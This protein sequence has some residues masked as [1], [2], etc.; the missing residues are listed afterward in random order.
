VPRRDGHLITAR[1]AGLPLEIAVTWL[2]WATVGIAIFATYSRFPASE[3]YNVSGTG[4]SGGLSRLFVLTNYPFGLVAIPVLAILAERLT[5]RRAHAVAVFG[6]VLAAAVFVPG[7]V[8][9]SDLDAK[10]VNAISAVGMVVALGFTLAALRQGIVRRGRGA[11]D[12]VRVAVC[13]A[14]VLVGLPWV[15]AEVG[16]YLTGV[17]GLRWLFQTGPY[18]D[19]GTYTGEDVAHGAIYTPG[20]HHGSHHGM[21]GVLLLITAALLSRVV[22]SIRRGRVRVSVG[23]YLALMAAYGIGDIANDFWT[24]QVVKRGWT[25]WG[26]PDVTRPTLTVAWAVIVVGTVLLYAASAWWSRRGPPDRLERS[27]RATPEFGAS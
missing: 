3:L 27:P 14:A 20:V 11:G 7:V 19:H 12:R 22:P 16:F 18:V 9:Q 15:A 13:A 23:L 26:I 8:T 6:I 2:L 25:S 4:I 24:E 17:P 10:P 5:D 1:S 21:D